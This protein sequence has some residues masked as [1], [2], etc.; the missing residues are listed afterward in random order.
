LKA[1]LLKRFLYS[2]FHHRSR[3]DDFIQ[4]ALQQ[5]EYVNN[6]LIEELSDKGHGVAYLNSNKIIIPNTIPGDIVN[7]RI[8]FLKSTHIYGELIHIVKKSKG[9]IESLCPIS[10]E[11]GGCQLQH[12]NY[13]YE[14]Q[15]KRNLIQQSFSSY[16]L[17]NNIHIP[18]VISAPFI[19]HYRNKIQFCIQKSYQNEIKIGLY[20]INSHHTIDT[21]SCDIAH[22]N[23]NEILQHFRL[24]L[25]LYP[26]DIY[27]ESTHHGSLRHIVIRTGFETDEIMIGLVSYTK[28]IPYEKEF[29]N[30]FK[31]NE[32]I[33][34]L[35]Y[36]YNPFHT[37]VVLSNETRVLYGRDYIYDTIANVRVKISLYSFTQSNPI[38]TKVLY[39][40]ILAYGEFS[41]NDTVFDLYCGVGTIGLFLAST[42]KNVIG[43]ED[44][45]EAVIDAN[46][47]KE[48]NKIENIKFLYGKAEEIMMHYD[49]TTI[50]QSIVIVDPPR[51]GCDKKLIQTILQN[52]VKRIVYVSCN[53]KTLARD[54]N[55]FLQSGHYRVKRVCPVDMFPNTFHV[56]VVVCLEYFDKNN[57][58]TISYDKL[59]VEAEI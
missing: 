31:T 38:Q 30:Y 1:N 21:L 40:T 3:S 54:L 9:R 17:L 35:L 25:S 26:I 42:V 4:S 37:D 58:R 14:L 59:M 16:N 6:I 20:E 29:I 57:A 48:L 15:Y 27:N 56:E 51:K 39:E 7:I 5:N 36:N 50:Q 34:S 52:K 24:F 28:T 53:T 33:K 19:R 47:N 8:L 11:C 18:K 32:K 2:P 23:I 44:C 46:M 45:Y 13:T 49:P 12:F 55:M 43:V 41:R 10:N 22:D